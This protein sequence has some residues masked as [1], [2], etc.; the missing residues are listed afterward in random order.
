[1]QAA[2]AELHAVLRQAVAALEGGD[3]PRAEATL[4]AAVDRYPR[5]HEA[6]NL[7]SVVTVRAGQAE[8]A[9]S[10]ARKAL[11]LERRNAIYHNNLGIACGEL[12]AL[13]EAETAFRRALKIQPA[14]PQALYNLGKVLHK[15]GR[16]D[17]AVR[18]YE[19]AHAMA[20]EEPGLRRNLAQLYQSRGEPA[21]ALALLREMAGPPDDAH[22]STYAACLAEASGEGAAI[23]WLSQMLE[24]R[25][26]WTGLRFERGVRRLALGQWR[27]GWS[28]YLGRPGVPPAERASAIPRRLDGATVLLC[29]EQG[30]GDTLFFLRFAGLLRA[31]GARLA[32]RC[33]GKLLAL[34]K[35]CPALDE[36]VDEDEPVTGGRFQH[37]LWLGDLPALLDVQTPEPAIVLRPAADLQAR[38]AGLGPRPYLALT[39]RAGTDMHRGPEFGRGQ[40]AALTKEVPLESL[41]TA[42]RGWPGTVVAL[43][44]DPLAGEIERLAALIGGSAHDLSGLNEDLVQ[45]TAALDALDE[46]VAVSNTNIHLRAGLGKSAR[47]LVPQPP[48]WRWMSDGER[49][50]WFPQMPV[51]RQP[52]SRNWSEPMERLRRELMP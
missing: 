30:L 49:S 31:R 11:E 2:L 39:W 34:L 42:V 46:Y 20:P 22:A 29:A 14:Y 1:M 40:R 4:R 32:L 38:L 26:D 48:E 50:P 24:H 47:V 8:L 27:E 44:R 5:A 43:Q 13:A 35:D 15:Q 21:R 51:Y 25:P 12:G 36:L 18:A 6:W 23:Q 41:A 28:D 3:L 16:L 45:M 17:D 9:A 52:A 33:P 19:R 37:T 7:L 10:C